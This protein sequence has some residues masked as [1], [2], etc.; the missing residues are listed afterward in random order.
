MTTNELWAII[1][2]EL[3]R[4]LAPGIPA[5]QWLKGSRLLKTG[6]IV[7]E[8]QVRQDKGADWLNRQLKDSIRKKLDVL[9]GH[10]VDLEIVCVE[11]EMA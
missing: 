4:E 7:Y 9:V 6:E 2:A 8:L 5:H 10:R 1:H 11:M 3:R